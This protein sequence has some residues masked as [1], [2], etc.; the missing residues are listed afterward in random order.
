MEIF[1]KKLISILLTVLTLF[2][3]CS[4]NNDSLDGT[5]VGPYDNSAIIIEGGKLYGKSKLAGNFETNCYFEGNTILIDDEVNP[6]EKTEYLKYDKKTNSLIYVNDENSF[7]VRTDDR[8]KINFW[9]DFVTDASLEDIYD[10]AENETN[11][12]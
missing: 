11:T 1:V 2:T 6:K 12:Q 8:E 7:W 4:C 9:K 3:F 5:Y 10:T